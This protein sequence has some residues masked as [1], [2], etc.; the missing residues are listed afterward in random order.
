MFLIRER[1]NQ[2]AHNF[3]AWHLFLAVCVMGLTMRY[4]LGSLEIPE[5]QEPRAK[6]YTTPPSQSLI[7][8]DHPRLK[9]PEPGPPTLYTPPTIEV[10][11]FDI[12]GEVPGPLLA[13]VLK[14]YLPDATDHH[15]DDLRGTLPPGENPRMIVILPEQEHVGPVY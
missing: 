13:S 6:W 10:L 12:T 14:R 11:P 1:E 7:D 5:E 4:A 8:H 9:H 15:A 2:D 3:R